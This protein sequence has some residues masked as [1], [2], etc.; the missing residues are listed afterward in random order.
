MTKKLKDMCIIGKDVLRKWN[1]APLVDYEDDVEK[2]LNQDL[3]GMVVVPIEPSYE[4]LHAA[5]QYRNLLQPWEAAY[6]AMLSAAQK[7]KCDE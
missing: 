5:R 2:A 6:K 4:M 3:S 1:Q 7:E